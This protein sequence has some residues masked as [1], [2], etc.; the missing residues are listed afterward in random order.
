MNSARQRPQAGSKAVKLW[1]VE[2]ALGGWGPAQAKFFDAGCIL[3][4][5]QSE[6]GARRMARGKA[7]A[8]VRRHSAV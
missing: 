4:K 8:V 3:D 1:N 6:V 2:D 5:I 7:G